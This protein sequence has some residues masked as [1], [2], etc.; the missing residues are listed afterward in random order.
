M[1]T[2]VSPQIHSEDEHAIVVLLSSDSVQQAASIQNQLVQIFGDAV[3]LQQPSGLH[4]TLM[5]IICDADYKDMPRLEHFKQWYKNYNQTV[6]DILADIPP[7]TIH[8]DELFVS[9]RAIIMKASNTRAYNDT[10]KKLLSKISLPAGTKVPPEITHSTLARFNKTIQ[11]ED[12]IRK[13]SNIRVDFIEPVTE[14]SLVKDLGPP[15]FNGTP[16]EVYP[17]KRSS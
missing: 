14:F 15:D 2:I 17:L 4:S 13:V 16:L 5:E 11:L 8:F 3:W 6:K 10:R 12:V 1:Q 7:F 9:Q